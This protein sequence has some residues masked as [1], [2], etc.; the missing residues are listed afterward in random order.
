MTTHSRILILAFDAITPTLES[1]CAAHVLRHNTSENQRTRLN[2]ME[3]MYQ[4]PA[5][6]NLEPEE[7]IDD[8]AFNERIKALHTRSTGLSLDK[9]SIS[10]L[11]VRFGR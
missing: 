2:V 1:I 4:I 11:H 10:D 5:I 6:V 8:P 3:S 7:T 9:I